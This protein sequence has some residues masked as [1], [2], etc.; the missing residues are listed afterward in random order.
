MSDAPS[1]IEGLIKAAFYA[2]YPRDRGV[3]A[4]SPRRTLM[5]NTLRS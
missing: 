3:F 5:K 4:A 1:H 2:T